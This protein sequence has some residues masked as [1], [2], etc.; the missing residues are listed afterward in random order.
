MLR[1]LSLEFLISEDASLIWR[2]VHARMLALSSSQLVEYDTVDSASAGGLMNNVFALAEKCQ[3][4]RGLP[5]LSW[6]TSLQPQG[7]ILVASALA[8]HAAPAPVAAAPA[9]SYVAPAPTGHAAPAPMVENVSPAQ[10]VRY[11]AP[12]LLWNTLLQLLRGMS[13]SSCDCTHRSSAS[14][15][16][17]P[18][19]TVLA[20][21]A[22]VMD[23]MSP[24]PA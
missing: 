20:A 12:A 2:A 24:A 16:L 17:P 18:T 1:I 13:P 21:S 7:S 10:A 22:P 3:V 11:G 19:P 15:Q 14:G 4:H 6:R 8:R 9:T 5:R 23:C